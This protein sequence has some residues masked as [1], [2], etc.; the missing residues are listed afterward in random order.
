MKIVFSLSKE[1]HMLS[2]TEPSPA[3]PEVKALVASFSNPSIER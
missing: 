2:I 3:L 1:L